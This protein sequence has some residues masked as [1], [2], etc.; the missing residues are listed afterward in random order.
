ML[1]SGEKI[2]FILNLSA[3][4]A[5][6]CCCALMIPQVQ[7][8]IVESG[9]RILPGRNWNSVSWASNIS[10]FSL[11]AG[12]CLGVF[13]VLRLKRLRSFFECHGE[14]ICVVVSA[15]IIATGIIVRVVM[16]AKCRS[17][18]LDEALLAEN[19]V[20]RNWSDLLASPLSNQQSA[21][22]LYVVA[23]K[24][25]CSALGY[26]E[27]SLRLFSLVSF[28]GLLIGELILLRKYLK[29]DD[30]KT[31][32]VLTITAVLPAYVYFSNELKPYMGDAFFVILTI[33]LYWLHT[34][35]NLSLTRL[36]LFY[37]LIL[38]FCSSSI[39]FVGGILATE[40]LIAAF[41]R[42]KKDT[43]SAL[44][45]GVLISAV[46]YLYFRWWMSPAL[47]FMT[48]Y[49][50][51][52]RVKR[53]TV[54]AVTAI[55]SPGLIS[56]SA[57]VWLFVPFALRG[58]Y[59]LIKR[60]D[61]VA[62]SVA[63]SLLLAFL[64]SFMGKWPLIGRLWLFLPAIVLTFSLVGLEFVLKGGKRVVD[65]AVFCLFSIITVYYSISCLEKVK[66]RMYLDRQEVNPLILYVKEHIKSDEKLYVY[67]PA[68][69]ALKYKN[70]YTTGRIG[71]SDRDNIIYGVTTEEWNDT[72]LGIGTELDTIIKSGKAYLL[73]QHHNT[74][75]NHGLTVLQ[76]YGTVTEIMN[77]HDTPLLYFETKN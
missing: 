41:A 5:I 48:E 44:I 29:F 34:Q 19:I 74:G 43:L 76:K 70:G 53:S 49:W 55:F 40:F 27:I 7:A 11:A 69:Y 58:V 71:N 36:T 61:K 18:W 9:R 72:S 30:I 50:C 2:K 13:S 75:I 32:F 65:M 6:L 31:V 1:T 8:F 54:A 46:F 59:L 23:V 60:K 39:F 15:A 52:Q 28:I 37:L 21:P 10:T 25:I 51:E 45:S 64:T 68:Q 62:Y 67:S 63:L 20:S 56:G 17:L 26:S 24:A 16:F 14:K 22:V 33:L 66:D 38:G 42:N 3:V 57:L 4:L 73:F 77:Y 35:K 12:I 47:D